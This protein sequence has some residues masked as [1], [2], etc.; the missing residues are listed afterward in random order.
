MLMKPRRKP[1]ALRKP[2]YF[3]GANV[4]TGLDAPRLL[5]LGREFEQ[6]RFVNC[7][8]S[9]AG[10]GHLRFEDCLFERCN[11]TTA[12]LG[13][14]AL[15]N[16]AFADC[17][18]LGVQFSACQDML[19]GVHFDH[20]QLRYAAFGG[21]RLAGTR[22]GHC[23]LDEADFTNADLTG[24]VF[25]HCDLTRTSF[26][27]TLLA[28]VDFTTATNLSLDP[29]ANTLSGA[30]FALAGLPGLLGKYGLVVE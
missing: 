11:L 25:A 29:E 30:R 17:K 22:F 14:T 10:L 23:T 4:L 1:A 16:V 18:L 20:C 21:K 8:L 15:Q 5:A 6:F 7:D 19:F 12:Q 24:A 2:D 27:N 13:G 28:G 26:H 9:A 3:P